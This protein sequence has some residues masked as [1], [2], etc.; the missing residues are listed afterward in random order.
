MRAAAMKK[1]MADELPEVKALLA[2]M[3]L[4]KK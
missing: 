2:D 3:E 4:A 1:Q